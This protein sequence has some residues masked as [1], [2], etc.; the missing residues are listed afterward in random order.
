MEI[1][2]KNAGETKKFGRDFA[3]KLK[4]GEVICLEGDLGSGKTTFVQGLAEGLKAKNRVVSP[5]FIL[6]RQYN[7]ENLNIFHLDLYRL[8]TNLQEELENL[9]LYEIWGRTSNVV[10]IEWAEKIK[11]LLPENAKWIHFKNL[12]E[13]E[14]II[15]T[16]E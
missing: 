9:G 8:E 14:R 2:T 12:S 11:E 4:G 10:L 5:T 13:E 1:V 15:T 3:T 6:M 7:G 16:N